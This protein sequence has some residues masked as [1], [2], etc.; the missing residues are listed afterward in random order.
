MKQMDIEKVRPNLETFNALLDNLRIMGAL[1]RKMGLKT[2]AEM[3]AC[4]VG[5]N[6]C[7]CSSL[8]I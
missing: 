3:K 6:S 4:G 1:G 5:K 2:V 7:K 8:F